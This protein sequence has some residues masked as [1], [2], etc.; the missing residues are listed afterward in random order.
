M[1]GSQ[2]AERLF[3]RLTASTKSEDLIEPFEQIMTIDS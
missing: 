3:W 1:K 2:K